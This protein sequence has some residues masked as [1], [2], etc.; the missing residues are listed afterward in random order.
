MPCEFDLGHNAMEA[1][2][3]TCWVKG[4]STVDHCTV[5]RGFKKFHLGCKN[6]NNQ[7]S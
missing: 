5:T 3:N 2:K 1:I 6:L 7:A 4:E